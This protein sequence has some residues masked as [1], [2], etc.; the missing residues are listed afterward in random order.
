MPSPVSA[1]KRLALAAFC[2]SLPGG[3]FAQGALTPQG[4][5]YALLGHQP[6]DQVRP[7]AALNAAGGIV[8]WQ[9]NRTDGDG[10]G[11]SAQRLDAAL[12]GAYGAFR[13][14]EAGQGDQENPQV[15]AIKGGGSVVV[16]QGGA[17][18]FQDVYARFIKADGT[19]VGGDVRVNTY[20]DDQ[21]GDAAVAGLSNGNVVVLWSS[22]GQDGHMQGVFGQVLTPGGVKVGS[23]FQVNQTTMYNQR[24]PAVAALESG[25]FVASWVSERSRGLV[26]NSSDSTG[27]TTSDSGRAV[28]GI[29]VFARIFSAAGEP[30]GTEFQ[31]N[32]SQ[33]VAA[34]PAVSAVPGGGFVVA[35][36]EDNAVD[37][38]SSWDVYARG[39]NAQGAPVSE[40]QRVNSYTY[41]DQY[42][43]R[44]S[45]AANGAL[46]TWTSLG[47]D[48]S[49]QGVFARL[50]NPQG[51]GA[52]AEFQVNTTT[53]G[54]QVE[55]SVA[56]DGVGRFLV[57]WS[58]FAAGTSFDLYA[59]RYA[60][61][62]VI[63]QPAAP[64]VSAL[65]QGKLMISWPELAGYPG[66]RYEVY[67]DGAT[68]NVVAGNHYLASGF[69]AS[70][71]HTVRLAYLLSTG[72]RSA[73]SVAANGHTWGEDDNGDGLPDD[74]QKLYWGNDASKWPSA[75]A[76]SDGDG[77]SNLREFLAGTNPVDGTSVLK[78]RFESGSQGVRLVWNTQPGS[79][80]Q[81]QSSADAATWVDYGAPRFSA[82]G[83]DS[84]LVPAQGDVNLFRLVRVR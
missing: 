53:V 21:Q 79:I 14:N 76:D 34:N 4:G 15:A 19:F 5:E 47:Q 44:V 48:G 1:G 80:L 7:Q 3:I 66:L 6:G 69:A 43:P 13:V 24:T 25:G 20:T 39:F 72:Q 77:V 50:I 83:T 52:G 40:P 81:V 57:V 71:D 33:N 51:A 30:A 35:W 73:L 45:A 29:D 12:A 27:A 64:F 56:Y 36:G 78:M 32:A 70:S 11:I 62:E 55:P 26:V 31:V 49:M 67:I 22:F 59:Q 18:G 84:I 75:S 8:V 61:G 28:F 17:Q 60:I 23:E 10:L 54:Q 38:A 74:W 46:V 2:L 42:A 58:G 16:W 37:R 41:G 65:S 82:G 9:D 63:P 68:A